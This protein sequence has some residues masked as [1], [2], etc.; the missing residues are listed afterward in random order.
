LQVDKET[1]ALVPLLRQ[2]INF[3]NIIVHAYDALDAGIV[4]KSVVNELP[5][6]ILKLSKILPDA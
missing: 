3:R 2:I 4:W 6:L 1:A 5:P